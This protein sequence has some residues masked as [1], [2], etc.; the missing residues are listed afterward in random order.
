MVYVLVLGISEILITSILSA[1]AGLLSVSAL[2]MV[3]L[4]LTSGWQGCY[5]SEPQQQLE[6]NANNNNGNIRIF[7]ITG[8]FH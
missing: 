8:V 3:H 1:S 5:F 6:L 4:Q 2:Q 7:S